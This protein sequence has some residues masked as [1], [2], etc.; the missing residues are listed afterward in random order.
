MSALSGWAPEFSSGGE[1]RLEELLAPADQRYTGLLRFW[2]DWLS[3]GLL[4][5][6]Q[7]AVAF[8][9]ARA[10]WVDEMPVLPVAT[11]IGL[12]V[13]AVLA[14]VRALT[15]A[16][17]LLGLAIGFAVSVAMVMQT[18]ELSDPLAGGGIATRWSELWGRMG[19]WLGALFGGGVSSDPLPFVLLM[20]FVV[21]F[22]PYVAAWAVFRWQNAW[23]ALVPAGVALLTNIS[24]LPGKPSFAFIVFLFAAMLLFARIHLLRTIR[25]WRGREIAIPHLLSL[26]V[27]FASAWVGVGLILV[28]WV[29]PTGNNWEP[30]AGAWNDAIRPVTDRLQPL[31]QVFIGIDGKRSQL[32]HQFEGVLPLQGRVRLDDETMYIVSIEASSVP[33]LRSNVFDEYDRSGWRLSDTERVEL[34]GTT[35]EAAEFGT[36]E[37]RAQVRRPVAVEVFVESPLSDRRLL[38]VG[39]PLA[40][41]VDA[42][43]LTGAS[44][45]DLVGLR[46]DSRVESGDSYTTVGTISAADVDQLITAGNEYPEWVL[47]RYLQLPDSLPERVGELA[48]EVAGDTNIAYVAAFQIERYLRTNY[49]FD[50]RVEDQPPRRDP[51]DFFLFESQAGYFDHHAT[52]MAVMLRTLGIPTRIAVGFS[53]DESSFD[54]ETRTH[55]LS[56][57]DSWAWPEVYFPGYGWVEFNPTPV[58]EVVNRPGPNLIPLGGGGGGVDDPLTAEQIEAID[59]LELQILAIEEARQ[60]EIGRTNDDG[61]SSV[62]SPAVLLGWL[63]AVVAA[64][65]VLLLVTRGAWAYPY[66][67]LSPATARWAKIQRLSSWAGVAV[68]SNRTPLE[69]AGELQRELEAEEPLDLLAS[70][71]TRERYGANGAG[72]AEPVED[73]AEVRRADAIYRAIRNRLFR[74]TLL[75]RLGFRRRSS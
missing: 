41:D 14:R 19:D 6:T 59:D 57:E 21:W 58:R 29:I 18:M 13:G 42:Q 37:T 70:N 20:V 67:G 3:F 55:V 27:V 62:A 34:P 49:A 61:G 35:V 64:G 52:V 66:R 26:E 1:R 73:D 31:G 7:F 45:D 23:L 48:A 51:V 33:H 44:R 5:A 71:F 28:A 72:E 30:A 53:L 9:I 46:P 32:V 68:P 69:A 75:R 24:Y 63:M 56:E 54:E 65:A 12:V 47:E 38:A 36:P 40:S 10:N 16:L 15:L 22:V 39:D 60:R 74:E 11:A 8:S 2:E 43:F 17:F 4:A 25:G 50:L